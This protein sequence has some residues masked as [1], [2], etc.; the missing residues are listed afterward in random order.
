MEKTCWI[1]KV[2]STL[3]NEPHTSGTAYISSNQRVFA[4]V[5]AIMYMVWLTV[6]EVWKQTYGWANPSM[7]WWILVVI[8]T[9]K[10]IHSHLR[11]DLQLTHSKPKFCPSFWYPCYDEY[12]T[13]CALRYL[14][15]KHASTHS[16]V[17]K[18]FGARV[19]INYIDVDYMCVQVKFRRYAVLSRCTYPSSFISNYMKYCVIG[20]TVL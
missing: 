4:S 6:Y 1:R 16:T 10:K 13:C 9:K 5:A 15:R 2:Q 3:S 8:S 12:D 11:N 14:S 20:Y 18:L 19:H 7:E 17:Q